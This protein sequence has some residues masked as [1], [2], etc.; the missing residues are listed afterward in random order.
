MSTL[1]TRLSK[2]EKTLAAELDARH[3]QERM[4]ALKAAFKADFERAKAEALA[5]GEAAPV[6]LWGASGPALVMTGVPRPP[7]GVG[8]D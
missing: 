4:D 6:P 8:E 3:A 1:A 2:L 7:D 5:H